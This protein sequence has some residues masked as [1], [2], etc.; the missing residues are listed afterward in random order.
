MANETERKTTSVDPGWRTRQQSPAR[1]ETQVDPGWREREQKAEGSHLRAEEAA[2]PVRKPTEVDPGWRNPAGSEKRKATI[3]DE[4]W[5]KKAAGMLDPASLMNKAT[6]NCFSS[7]EA[8][9]DAVEKLS[10]LTSSTGNVY[11]VKKTL[12]REGGESVILLCADPDGNDVVAKVYYEPVNGAGSSI[13]T[14]VRVLEYMGTEEG[15]RYTLAVSEIGLVSFHDSKYYFEIMP[16]SPNADLSSWGAISFDKLVE[17]TRQLNEALHSIHK[18]G[19]F[20]RDIKP[21]NLYE[22]DGQVK[23]GDFG[24]ARVGAIGINFITEHILGTEGYAAPETRRYI[25]GEKSDYYSLGVTLATLFEGHFI[26]ENM[27]YEM[28][29]LAQ[30]AEKLP[31]L[32]QDPHRE[33][34]EN[35]VNGLCRINTRQRFGYEEVKR[36][37]ENHNYSGGASGDLWPK[38]YTMLDDTY[39]DEQSMFYGISRNREYW[40]E[41]NANLY[42]RLFE[43]FFAS[44]RPNLARAAQFSDEMYRN[45]NADKGLAI[46]LNKLYRAGPIVWKGETFNGLAELGEAILSAEDLTPYSE[47]LQ[48]QCVSYWLKNTEGITVD[49]ETSSLV[50][51]IEALSLR[52]PEL[53][54]CWFGNSFVSEKRLTINGTR[55]SNIRQLLSALLRSPADFYLKDGCTKLL[56]KTAGADLYGFL[57][58]L[59]YQQPVEQV[60]A[61]LDGCDLFHKA[62]LLFSMLEDIARKDGADL[63][64]IRAFFVDYGPLGPA[65]Y[66]RRL[67]LDPK[68]PVY[69]A[70]N[71]EGKRLLS[72]IADFRPPADGSVNELFRAYTP[73]LEAVENL[74][75]KLVEN[76]HCILAGAYEDKG[77]ICRDLSGCF[78]FRFLD[79]HAPLGFHALLE[80]TKGGNE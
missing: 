42:R 3:V 64:R 8:F 39:Y 52:E 25:F 10:Q 16:Y 49:E 43:Q 15:R 71:G 40:E 11:S 33:Q 19:I 72:K 48:N 45:G 51:R 54:C 27:N 30:E 4:G 79:R 56:D 14:R 38:G 18:A 65:S 55:V 46:F 73:L 22:I 76:P 13:S 61:N 35:L 17:I 7:R 80:N 60:W 24:I 20:H 75:G 58:S 36:W 1:R 59:G 21:Q 9:K 34:V 37:L 50:D 63:S 26:F 23:L 74:R 12:S 57:Y 70:L 77:V 41:A 2:T 32:R 69:R 29:A 6:A 67:V 62:S 68:A 78:A 44:F 66:T 28:T 31:F 53:A 5:R 47:M